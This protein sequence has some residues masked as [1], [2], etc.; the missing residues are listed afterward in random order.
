MND[1]ILHI[2]ESLVIKIN[3]NVSGITESI[4]QF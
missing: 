1:K 4:K 3:A 2:V